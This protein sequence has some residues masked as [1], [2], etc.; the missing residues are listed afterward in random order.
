MK[1]FMMADHSPC[2]TMV[3]SPIILC[4]FYDHV[5]TIQFPFSGVMTHTPPAKNQL[6]YNALK[7]SL[8]D[9]VTKNNFPGVLLGLSGGIDSALS[10]VIAV[11]ALGADKVH[12]VMMPSQYTSQESLDMMQKY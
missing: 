8:H 6:I 9:Y 12:C 5:E 1:P 3:T 2:T 11:D 7:T 10:A 4:F